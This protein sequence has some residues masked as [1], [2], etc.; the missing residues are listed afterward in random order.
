MFYDQYGDYDQAFAKR[1]ANHVILRPRS[2]IDEL[3]DKDFAVIIIGKRPHRQFPIAD[4]ISSLLSLIYFLKNR[5]RMAPECAEIAGARI[6]E[7]CFR[8]GIETPRIMQ[9]YPM[10]VE[11][12]KLDL[13]K[14]ANE[15]SAKAIEDYSHLEDNMFGLVLDHD[16]EKLRKFPMPDEEH[17][18][19]AYEAAKAPGPMKPKLREKLLANIERRA[20]ELGIVLEEE[21]PLNPNFERDIRF[22]SRNMEKE[23]RATY[24][25]VAELVLQNEIT[26]KEACAVLDGINKQNGVNDYKNRLSP[27][28]IVYG[29]GDNTLSKYASVKLFTEL[30]NPG[31]V[32]K[33]SVTD[34]LKAALTS[35]EFRAKLD[36]YFGE[37]FSADL[38]KDTKAIF[39]SLPVPH[40]DIIRGLLQA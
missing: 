24:E 33:A 26:P 2:D 21:A 1:L 34:E 36:D 29:S 3:E 37:G 27:K 9:E 35:E 19:K 18:R 17:V 11:S 8:F 25:K 23:A 5:S 20:K 15:T 30:L 12:F 6:K 14:L 39:D 28:D 10:G 32:K 16:G 22:F 7:A 31:M 13:E 4:K 38:S 40:K